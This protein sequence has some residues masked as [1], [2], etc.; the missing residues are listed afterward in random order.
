MCIR[1]RES[2]GLRSSEPP[3]LADLM[4][5]LSRPVSAFPAVEA[6]GI[7]VYKRQIYT[8][9]PDDYYEDEVE[10]MEER[11]EERN[12]RIEA[13][14]KEMLHD[15]R[16]YAEKHSEVKDYATVLQKNGI[17][18]DMGKMKAADVDCLNTCLLYTSR[19]V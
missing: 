3:K 17:E 18:L 8:Y 7:D 12:S 16:L 14:S 11:L 5:R 1:D 15:V 4:Q 13:A 6:R 10:D 2:C 19:C 9:D